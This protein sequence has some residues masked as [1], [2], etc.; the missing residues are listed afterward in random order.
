M[1]LGDIAG[2]ALGGV[3]RFI[4]RVVFEIVVEWLLRG[5]GA[6]ILRL[7]RPRHEPDDA[8]AILTG[9]VFW[10]AMIAL[11]FWVYEQAAP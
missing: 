3:F 9:L 2:E 8:T 10:I 6:L 1:P 5:T 11:G 7:I 4:A